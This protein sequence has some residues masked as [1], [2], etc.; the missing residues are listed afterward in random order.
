LVALGLTDSDWSAFYRL[1]GIKSRIDHEALT[2]WFFEATLRHLSPPEPYVAVVDGVQLP[3][4]SHK[5]PGS[6]WLRSP[7][8]PPFMAGIHRAQ[9]FMHL[10]ELLAPNEEG[11]SPALP[12]RWEPA[13]TEKA[14]PADGF[15][16]KKE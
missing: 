1:F 13:F 16:P 8:T 12:L 7:R 5:M 9:R 4:H 15:E 6:C 10:A 2:R 3:R 14:V 11:Y